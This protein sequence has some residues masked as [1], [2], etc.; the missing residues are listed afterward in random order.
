VKGIKG[1]KK[2]DIF[3]KEGAEGY[4]NSCLSEGV[5]AAL[6]DEGAR[7]SQDSVTQG[8]YRKDQE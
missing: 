3:G 8:N 5:D 6:V 2:A 4:W 1:V 7:L